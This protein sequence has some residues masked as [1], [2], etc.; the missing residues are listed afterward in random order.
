MY[1]ELEN[2]MS[3]VK[4]LRSTFTGFIFFFACGPLTAQV[5]FTTI[6]SSK[7]IGKKEFVQV[8]FVV[9]NA[10]K[11]ENITAPAIPED[12]KIVE[13]P[14]QSSGMSIVNGNM[15][16]YKAISYV[17]QP[18][19]TGKFTIPGATAEIDGKMIRSN[20]VSLVV[21]N[22]SSGNSNNSINPMPQPVFPQEEV[23]P[24]D[25][26]YILKPGANIS[27]EIKKNLFVK[28]LVDKH[29]CYVGEPIM[30]TYKLYTRLQSDSRVTKQPSLNGFSVYDMVDPS[31][32]NSSVEKING[33]SF[34]VHTIRK[35]QLIPLQS[36]PIE[37]SQVEVE[38]TVH[39]LKPAGKQTRRNNNLLQSLLDDLSES[40][41]R[42]ED[43][44]Q[45]VTLTSKPTVITVKP[46]PELNKPASFN[47]AVGQF[48]MNAAI[49]NKNLAAQDAA[50]LKLTINGSGNLPVLNAPQVQWPSDINVFNT[51]SKEDI[52][53]TVVPMNGSKT[54]EYV[55]TAKKAGYYDIPPIEFSYFDP[56]SSSYKI[57][58]SDALNFNV[59]AAKKQSAS[60]SNNP[61]TPNASVL[62]QFK[63][64]FKDHMEWFFAVIIL[65]IVGLSLWRH[66]IRSLK[67]EDDDKQQAKLREEPKKEH[68]IPIISSHIPE[69]VDPLLRTKEMLAQLNYSGF[70][71]ELNLSLWDVLASKLN[72]P[73]SELNK[74]NVLSILKAKGWEEE[75]LSK[76]QDVMNK[77]EMNLYTPDYNGAGMEH[78]LNHA[79]QV[80]KYVNEV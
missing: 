57:V 13:G 65:S 64:F 42:G 12:F 45:Q 23:S 17:L 2:S 60:L 46:L 37:M 77:C 19:K 39:F 71:R 59:S 36:G 55:F 22:S 27:E 68:E 16:Q 70:Y 40:N 50:T 58:K 61:S 74:Q 63:S 43:I 28:L 33:K 29:T 6:L 47:G 56:T 15:S 30:A 34:T 35:A 54:Y 52:D 20:P 9:E 26:E 62:T 75:N 69:Q 51:S 1:L 5:K 24:D 31:A 25:R 76:L 11:I 49:E 38:N 53:K 32:D 3:I 41:M 10:K 67:K 73:A 7:E 72:L 78:I 80:I 21:N 8:E 48:T 18:S 79:E 4:I 14:V 66:N 44:Q